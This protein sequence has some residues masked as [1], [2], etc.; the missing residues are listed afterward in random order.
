MILIQKT[1]KERRKSKM[2]HENKDGNAIVDWTAGD[3]QGDRAFMFRAYRAFL[4]DIRET[5]KDC[6]TIEFLFDKWKVADLD[7]D[8]FPRISIEYP[9]DYPQEL[10]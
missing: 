6:P 4:K 1:L 2:A 3:P 7:V 9:I 10:K 5:C 8:D